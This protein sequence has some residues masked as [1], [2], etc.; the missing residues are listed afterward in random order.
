MIRKNL[1]LGLAL[2]ISLSCFVGH[3]TAQGAE[4]AIT[5]D[6]HLELLRARLERAKNDK[7]PLSI[8]GSGH[9][10]G[11]H[12]DNVKSNVLDI[13]FLKKM[14]MISR[15][16]LRVQTGARW[17]QVIE[18]LNPQGLSVDV[19][20]SDYDFT[21]G[22][23]ISTNVHG[24]RANKPPIN[25]TIEGFHLLLADGS[26]LYCNRQQNPELFSAAI[27]G[28]GLLG[29][30]TDVDI[31]VVQNRVYKLRQWV[32]DYTSFMPLFEQQ[33]RKNSQ[34]RLFFGRFSVQKGQFLRNVVVRIYED[35]DEQSVK[36]KLSDFPWA[37]SAINKFFSWSYGSGF[38]K[39]V[40]WRMESSRWI[41]RFYSRLARNQLLYHSVRNYTSRDPEQ[42]DRLQEYF[43]PPEQFAKFTS[44]LQSL[45]GE[46]GEAV[47]NI[48]I[49]HVQQD[50]EIILRYAT[51]ERIAFV[52][53]FRGPRGAEFENSLGSVVRKITD[54]VLELGGS[55]YLPYAPYQTREQ[56][57]RSYPIHQKFKEILARHD[58]TGLFSNIFYQN[59]LA[60]RQD[61]EL[62]A[63]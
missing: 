9:S 13:S 32:V 7:V 20:Q 39:K 54:Y 19:M 48:T 51:G 52:C 21:V 42:V 10:Q 12:N 40:R 44:Y 62:S 25:D 45:Q 2:F 38:F 18:F 24:W 11:G 33:V 34:V 53:F 37:E 27:G 6:A 15:D 46:L 31:K 58:P 35:S 28:Y 14:E 60:D 49:R 17:S 5:S 1:R 22:G 43:I 63:P 61:Q 30:I 57:R 29:I 3:V 36:S 47:M 41:S 55:Y 23:S 16:V 4:R 50:D 8:V 56:F 59:Y 26:Y